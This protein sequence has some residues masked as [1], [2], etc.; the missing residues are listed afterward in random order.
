MGNSKTARLLKFSFY[1]LADNSVTKLFKAFL[2][3]DLIKENVLTCL[4]VLH[5]N[6]VENHILHILYSIF[7]CYI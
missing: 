4:C 1:M 2:C 6:F 3:L 5:I 7:S